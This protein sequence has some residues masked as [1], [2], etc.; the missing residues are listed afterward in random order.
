M[1]LKPEI[2]EGK[3]WVHIV[4]IAVIVLAVLKYVFNH[5]MFTFDFV[6]KVGVAVAIADITAHT[7][8]GFD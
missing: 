5:D 3:Y 7:L 2:N 1:K 6:W 8:L 4:V